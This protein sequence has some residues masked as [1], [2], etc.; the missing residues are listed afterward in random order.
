[1]M[2]NLICLAQ[3]TTPPPQG[4]LMQMF[5]ML[6]IMMGI[7][8]FMLIRPQRRKEKERKTMMDSI[9]SGDRVMF[10]GGILGTVT[11]TKDDTITIRI[12]DGVKIDV[13]RGGINKVLGKDEKV[14]TDVPA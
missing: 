5:P 12:A 2:F 4:G 3:A 9:K 7:F 14:G 10:G 8:Y 13:A 1:M 11:N 6:A